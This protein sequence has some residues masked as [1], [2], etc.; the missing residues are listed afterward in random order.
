MADLSKTDG[1]VP[2]S[3]LWDM[4]NRVDKWFNT[5]GSNP[6]KVYIDIT[7][8][9][10]WVLF[11]TFQDMRMRYMK[12]VTDEGVEP[13]K[14]YFQPPTPTTTVNKPPTEKSSLHQAVEKAVGTYT[15]FTEYYNQIK[16]KSWEGYYNDVYGL[17]DEVKRLTNNQSLNCTDHSQLGF[18]VAKDLWYDV[19]YCRVTC[20]SGGHIMLQVK[21]YELGSNW[22][23]VDLAA[24]AS[25]DYG[26]GSY[27]C[28]SYAKPV[29]IDEAWINSNDGIT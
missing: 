1:Y 27:W 16:K 22:V 20:K 13:T 6:E 4:A 2:L 12:Y 26:I 3:K 18:A 19:R 9:K 21:G 17:G 14:I 29:V 7:T 5:N 15:T 8:K 23:N 25:S 24:A 11:P 10:D 28:S